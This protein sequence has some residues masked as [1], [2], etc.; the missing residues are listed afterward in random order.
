ML[1]ANMSLRELPF[2][3]LLLAGQLGFYLA[4]MVAAFVPARLKVLRPLRLAWMFTM[5]NSALF[6]GFFRWLRGGQKGVWRR[7]ERTVQ[8]QGVLQ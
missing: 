5:M 6:M 7:T 4:S 1:L 8:A 2:Y 3:R